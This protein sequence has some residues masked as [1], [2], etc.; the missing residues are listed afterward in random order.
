M[1]GSA[2]SLLILAVLLVPLVLACASTSANPT[3]GQSTIAQRPDAAGVV[4]E[5][6][7]EVYDR[8]EALVTKV[9]DGD[10]IDVN[11]GGVQYKLRY[12]GIN[13]P[14]LDSIDTNTRNIAMKA[15]DKNRELVGGKTVEL[16]K[17]VSETD[18]YGRLLRYVYAGGIMVNAE[19]VRCGYAQATPY[20][21]DL[22]YQ[23]V[24]SSLQ[25]GAKAAK[26]G[27]W[28]SAGYYAAPKP[29][30]K[31]LYVGSTKSNKYHYPT[32]VWAQQIPAGN[33][34]WFSSSQ[35]ALSR[36]YVPCKVCGPPQ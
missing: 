24:F 25:A 7:S 22:R 9:V 12:I 1:T 11:V 13:A 23:A 5:A 28:G 20:P 4:S 10:T 21:P 19:L 27:I 3:A 30:E 36:G 15:T 16:E 17:D 29:A 8:S 33:E 31:G 32:C 6:G 2:R 18:K 26:A 35:E 34:I 14:E